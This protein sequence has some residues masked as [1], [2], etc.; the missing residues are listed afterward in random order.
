MGTKICRLCGKSYTPLRTNSVF[1]DDCINQVLERREKATAHDEPVTHCII[2][3]KPIAHPVRGTFTCSP[4]CRTLH[5]IL[6]C[7]RRYIRGVK[8]IRRRQA[9]DRQ[10]K[11]VM[12]HLGQTLAAARAAGL[13]Y[14]K[15]V[16]FKRQRKG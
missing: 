11:A 12:S 16:A 4:E 14:G 2:C 10:K 9:M 15:Y 5:H 13:S 1:C 6:S 8:A 3:G 7:N